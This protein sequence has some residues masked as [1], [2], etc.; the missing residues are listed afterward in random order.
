MPSLNR[1]SYPTMS[2]ITIDTSG[3][4][5]LL[6]RLNPHEAT[7]QDAI[8]AH[9]LCELSNEVAS[10]SPFAFQMSLDTCQMTGV[11]PIFSG[12]T[13]DAVTGSLNLLCCIL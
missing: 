12:V 3:V 11:W 4:K 5:N 1:S 2:H 10:A 6:R 9:L 8:P 7:G 13:S